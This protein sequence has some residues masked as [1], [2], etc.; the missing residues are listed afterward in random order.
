MLITHMS[1]QLFNRHLSLRFLYNV[2]PIHQVYIVT[3]FSIFH[4][5]K[6]IISECLLIV[7][8]GTT[9]NINISKVEVTF[10][11]FP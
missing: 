1:W 8:K 11:K 4:L 10:I 5:Y 3:Y 7:Y 6:I 9:R 2:F